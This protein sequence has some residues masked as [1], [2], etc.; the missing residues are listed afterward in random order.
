MIYIDDAFD[1][2]ALRPADAAGRTLMGQWVSVF[3]SYMDTPVVRQIVIQRLVVPTR[4]GEPDE[5]VIAAAVP[6]AEHIL[7]VLDAGLA[8][9]DFLLGDNVGIANFMVFPAIYYLAET[10]EGGTLL[11]VAGYVTA[12]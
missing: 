9:S 6:K 3:L 5:A 10:L 11:A 7:S 8:N 1:G 2:P 4:G 12:W